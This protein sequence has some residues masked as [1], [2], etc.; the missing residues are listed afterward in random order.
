MEKHLL[1][2]AGGKGE[3]MQTSGYKQFM[4]LDG[5][6]LLL[7][8]MDAFFQ[9]DPNIHCTIILPD[10]LHQ[11]WQNICNEYG[12]QPVYQLVEGG[13][14]RFHSVK[15]GLKHIPDNSLVAIHDAARP[16]VSQQLIT[17]LFNFAKKFGNAIPTIEVADSVR[18]VNRA[19]NT[20]LPREQIRL[21]QTPQ[22]F[23]ASS[24]KKAY[25]TSYK[26]FYTDDASVLEANGER[27]YLIDGEKENFKITTMTDLMAADSIFQQRNQK[28]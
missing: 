7:R 21:V 3:R 27:L 12:C 4:K 2:A 20:A 10:A 17:R 28:R 9:F 15:N 19:M 1:I 8:V 25:N 22:C 26:D 6:P 13:P 11:D 14:T 24:I 18:M 16:L 23:H 5:K